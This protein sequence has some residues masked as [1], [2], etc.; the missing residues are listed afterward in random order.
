MVLFY[1]EF[2]A[3]DMFSPLSSPKYGMEYTSA[4]LVYPSRSFN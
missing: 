2:I 4:L 3:I 1:V